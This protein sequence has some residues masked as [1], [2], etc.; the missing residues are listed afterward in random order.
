MV[1]TMKTPAL[2]LRRRTLGALLASVASWLARPPAALAATGPDA[3]NPS[4]G[5]ASLVAG[6][7]LLSR[8]GQDAQALWQG[9]LLFQGDRLDTRA[10][11][12]LHISFEDGGYLA[13]RP[14]SALTIDSYIVTGAASD[15]AALRLL[16]GALRSVT[17]W[18]GKLEP[19]RYS[20]AATTVFVGV[21]GTDHEV[22]VVPPEEATAEMA[23]GVHNRVNEGG[24]TLRNDQG[25]I[26]I[27]PGHA[28]YSPGTGMAPRAHAGVPAF[29]DRRH[30]THEAAAVEHARNIRQHMEDRLRA[31]GK[32]QGNERF[33]DFRQRHASRP[34]ARAPQRGA[35]A[36]AARAGAA[37]R[38]QAWEEGRARQG[39]AANARRQEAGQ[40]L[41][42]REERVREGGERR[43]GAERPTREGAYRHHE[44]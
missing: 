34:E 8:A 26:D 4:V 40:A 35:D 44:K 18:I 42:A 21:R 41:R 23:A 28:A 5:N 30:T 38:R 6:S 9:A 11:G 36:P 24:T 12:E 31:R 13:L 43:E 25:S 27:D 14:N 2:V 32:L 1:G 7:V 29:F 19:K 10:D 17:G 33:E 15:S 3:S 39:E 37:Q 20:L 16:R 22:I